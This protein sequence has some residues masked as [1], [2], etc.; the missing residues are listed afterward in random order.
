[1]PMRAGGASIRKNK[2]LIR[3]GQRES[4]IAPPSAERGKLFQGPVARHTAVRIFWPG[5]A[6]CDHPARKIQITGFD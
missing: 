5:Q 1:M 4:Q 6:N 3:P 2:R